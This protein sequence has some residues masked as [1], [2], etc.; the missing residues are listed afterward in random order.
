MSELQQQATYIVMADPAIAGVGSSVGTSTWNASA[1]RG[2][3]FISLKP[4]SASARRVPGT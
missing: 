2:Q 4:L 1:N 3:L